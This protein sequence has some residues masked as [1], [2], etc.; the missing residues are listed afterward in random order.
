MM[1]K[2]IVAK[3]TPRA[4]NSLL[5]FNKP[6]NNITLITAPKAINFPREFCD[7][8]AITPSANS[9]SVA[10]EMKRKTPIKAPIIPKMNP[11]SK[12]VFC[13]IN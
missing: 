7:F 13:I 5:N 10:N 8:N 11:M 2:A 6:K 4:I 12:S 3:T 9:K 1:V